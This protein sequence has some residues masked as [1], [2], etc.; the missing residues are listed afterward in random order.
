MQLYC[1]V[2][3][4]IKAPELPGADEEMLLGYIR[5]ASRFIAGKMGNF[6]PQIEARTF[7][8]EGHD[9]L[10]LQAPLLRVTSLTHDGDALTAGVDYSLEPQERWWP[11]GPYSRL[12]VDPDSLNLGAWLDL[13][14]AVAITGWWGLYDEAVSLQLSAVSQLIGDTTISVSDGSK[15]SPG[16]LLLIESEWEEV[17]GLGTMT[18]STATTNGALDN[19]TEEITLSNGALVKVGEVIKVN[20]ERMLVLDIEGNSVQVTRGYARTKKASHLTG[21]TVY[22]QRAY[23]VGRGANGSTAAAHTSAAVSRQI[24]PADVAYLCRQLAV[25]EWKKEATGFAGRQ[26]TADG[27]TFY[28]NEFPSAIAKI[29]ENYRFGV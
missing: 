4:L 11:G 20:F 26:G 15:I 3:E 14:G 22:V 19:A 2:S 29:E 27:E 25:L 17:T 10:F 8:G 21:Q 12:A 6:L 13:P 16:M 28:F 23:T 7:R 5:S 1:A 24:A 18:D 9:T